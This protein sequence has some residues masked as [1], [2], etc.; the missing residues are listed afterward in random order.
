MPGAELPGLK[1][2]RPPSSP[3]SPSSSSP[4][5]ALSEDM[6]QQIPE[7][8]SSPAVTAPSGQLGAAATSS[9]LG[10]SP[11]RADDD[12]SVENASRPAAIASEGDSDGGEWV[13][14]TEDV[15]LGDA[16]TDGVNQYFDHYN[17]ILC[18]YAVLH[19][20]G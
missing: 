7:G 14:R 12:V 17:Q 4:K 11:L 18:E 13:K 15:H 3:P 1:R 2:L 8:A 9:A 16:A 5:R 19:G 10:S 6:F 20:R